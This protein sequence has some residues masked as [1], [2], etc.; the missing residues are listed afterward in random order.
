MKLLTATLVVLFITKLL[1]NAVFNVP[2][3]TEYVLTHFPRLEKI[4]TTPA[5]KSGKRK[6]GFKGGRGGVP[7]VHIMENEFEC[8]AGRGDR[9][10]HFAA[11]FVKKYCS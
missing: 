9:H 2:N 1:K 7:G 3:H 5:T 6:V 8:L 10:G 11:E 4:E